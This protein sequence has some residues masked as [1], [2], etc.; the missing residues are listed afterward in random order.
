MP[1][2]DITNNQEN[3]SQLNEIIE[4]SYKFQ[5]NST[6]DNLN[7]II[8]TIAVKEN[9]DRLNQRI[10]LNLEMEISSNYKV[11]DGILKVK[12][13]PLPPEKDS[14]FKKVFG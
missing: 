9:A 2:F 3:A 11:T 10:E 5:I 1:L 14:I 8:D 4:G 6:V 12:I 7:Q 13:S